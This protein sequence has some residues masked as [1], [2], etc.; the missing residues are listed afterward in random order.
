LLETDEVRVFHISAMPKNH[1]RR[2]DR[3]TID[4]LP[5]YHCIDGGEYARVAAW[6]NRFLRAQFQAVLHEFKPQVTHFHNYLSLGDDL[7][8]DGP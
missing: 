4:G 6:P 8:D 3:V 1:P 7:V 2:L 5:T